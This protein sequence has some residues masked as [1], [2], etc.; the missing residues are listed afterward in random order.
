MAI[1]KTIT[2]QEGD[3]PFVQIEF[4]E[5]AILQAETFFQFC[6][7]ANLPVE[8]N[9]LYDL[10]NF[11]KVARLLQYKC[12][13]TAEQ[14]IEFLHIANKM[15]PVSAILPSNNPAGLDGGAVVVDPETG[16]SLNY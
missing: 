2:I 16:F 11:W 12:Y 3:H 5:T 14:R 7:Q 4:I 6:L 8:R 13:G 15:D 1:I 10:S 9:V